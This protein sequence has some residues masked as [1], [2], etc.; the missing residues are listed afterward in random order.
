MNNSKAV[1]QYLLSRIRLP[2]SQGE[3]ES[4]VYSV[5]AHFFQLTHTDV[6][7]DK[8]VVIGDDQ[9]KL[10][11]SVIARINS[12]EPIQYITGVAWFFRRP[13]DVSPAVLIP[14]PETE[15]LIQEVIAYAKQRGL[16]A[17]HI[18]DL[19]TGSG[20]IPVTLGLEIPRSKMLATDIS[21]DALAVART[22]ADKYGVAVD[23]HR[24]NILKD[25]ITLTNFDIIT[26]NPPYIRES[27]KAGMAQNVLGFEPHLALFVPEDDPLLF[28]KVIAKKAKS[29]LRHEGMLIVEVNEHF[30]HAV[31]E[32][33]ASEGF[34][35]IE[36]VYD[37]SQKQRIVRGIKA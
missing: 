9:L 17:A 5:L 24:H 34:L 12:N 37:L 19:C 11:D 31:A 33:F 25:P 36:I 27:E 10:L 15:E 4:I 14:R 22:N 13:F 8:P 21:D 6:L 26:A 30:G 2:E 7:R 28:Y 1:Q 18:L 35:K 3:N 20:C 16:I 29:A 23:F 32:V